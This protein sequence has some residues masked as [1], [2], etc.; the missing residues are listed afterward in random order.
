MSGSIV[1]IKVPSL[2]ESVVEAVVAKWCKNAGDRV[3][4]DEVIAELETDKVTM[5]V[6]ASEAGMIKE[7]V[8]SPGTT[9]AIGALLGRIET[10]SVPSVEPVNSANSATISP[11]P[12]L[13]KVA[14]SPAAERI[15]FQNDIPPQS[16][17]GT[18]KNGLITREDALASVD[19]KKEER[20]ELAPK[21]KGRQRRVP[22]TK[23]RQ[24]ISSHLKS[25][26]NEA[27]ILTTFNEIDMSEVMRVRSEHQEIFEKKHGV[28]LG[29]MSFFVK[30][31]VQALKEFPIINAVIDD[32]A[33][34]IIHQDFYDIG[35]AVATDNGLVVPV[36]RGADGLSLADLEKRIVDLAGRARGNKL[37][38]DDLS[39]GTFSITNGGIYGSLFSTP[40]LN[41][42]QSAILGMHNIVERPIVVA[43]EIV[44][45]PMMYIALSYDHRL[46]DG[47]DAVRFLGKVKMMIEDIEAMILDL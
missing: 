27:A 7:I 45:R 20:T 8:A 28:K 10:G 19:N 18:G 42:G 24:A 5:E 15:L 33:K 39:G 36:I 14:A 3:K 9:V 16:V 34:E 11:N 32:E 21:D 35:V 29:L 13:D 44:I 1:D 31:V 25:V 38:M 37:T 46:I 23:M 6:V 30:S 4:K 12:L 2:G 41:R 22:M 17:V 26:Q 47:K 40:I 43:G